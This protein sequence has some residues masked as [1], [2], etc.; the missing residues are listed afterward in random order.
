MSK[1]GYADAAVVVGL[2]PGPG[3]VFGPVVRRVMEGAR[4]GCH[5]GTEVGQGSFEVSRGL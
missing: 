1:P 3:P 2:G 5:C 4:V